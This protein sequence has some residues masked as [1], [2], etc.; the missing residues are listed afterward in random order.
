MDQP[1]EIAQVHI[2]EV[3]RNGLARKLGRRGSRCRSL[4][5]RRS[6]CKR[7]RRPSGRLRRRSGCCDRFRGG[8]VR[9][10]L[11]VRRWG[12][13]S[14]RGPRQRNRQHS[15]RRGNL[16]GLCCGGLMLR[17]GS[18]IAWRRCLYLDHAGRLV[19]RIGLRRP[20]RNRLGR[21]RYADR[22]AVLDDVVSRWL[23]Q[24]DHDARNFGRKLSEADFANRVKI[25][26]KMAFGSLETRICEI[27]HQPIR[28]VE[29]HCV[30]GQRSRPG[31]IDFGP[32]VILSE[33]NLADRGR[34]PVL[35]SYVG[36]LGHNGSHCRRLRRR[37]H[38]RCPRRSTRHQQSEI[39]GVL[40]F[41]AR[42][43]ALGHQ[44]FHAYDRL[45][46][47]RI[48]RD[49]IALHEVGRHGLHARR[50]SGGNATQV[51]HVKVR[52]RTVG[53]VL[54]GR[55][56]FGVQA[57]GTVLHLRFHMDHRRVARHGRHSIRQH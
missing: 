10:R 6:S 12:R 24:I 2:L 35:L 29:P 56:G 16:A 42:V 50:I 30:V 13:E 52:A 45:G 21:K 5:N 47:R 23:A 17:Q 27:Q 18:R 38:G 14:R 19:R 41:E 15:G 25:A 34:N 8:L 46:A 39:L 26:R 1:E 54:E 9:C 49:A 31:N 28:I 32:A 37:S 7:R 55:V 33:V 20:R 48:T 57:H 11:G 3:H 40:A 36:S 4:G 43:D 44:N 51:E 53:A 22:I